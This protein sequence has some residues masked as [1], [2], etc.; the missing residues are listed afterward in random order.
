[1][2]GDFLESTVEATEPHSFEVKAV[3]TFKDKL[4][5]W[6][7]ESYEGRV[8]LSKE[9]IHSNSIKIEK[10]QSAMLKITL[11]AMG[12][13]MPN[14][15]KTVYIGPR[16]P[17]IVK[18]VYKKLGD[19]VQKGEPLA[20]IESN[21]SMQNYEIKSEINGMV[22]KKDINVGMYLSGQE[23]VFVISDL[24]TVW[25][26]FNIYRHDLPQVNVGDLVE[27]KSLDGNINQETTISYISPLGHE[28]TQSVVARAVLENPVDLWKPGL[29]I[30]GE[31]TVDNVSVDVA[32]KD[33]ALQTFRDWDVV[34]ISSGDQFEVVP[35]EIGR[36]NK[37]WVEITSG[38]SNGDHYVTEN[39]YILKADL[40]KSGAKHEH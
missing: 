30:T 28:S 34:F 35:V 3:A 10:A 17:G 21:E 19:Y 4:H 24:S 9:A 36:R 32:I 12:K 7:Y 40:E 23:N 1:M 26:D 8:V 22:I 15:E 29:F 37:E 11:N 5:R 39:S 16:F 38:L 6:E 14:E 31:I 27:V 2:K 13:I 18:G 20:V 33:S 25:A